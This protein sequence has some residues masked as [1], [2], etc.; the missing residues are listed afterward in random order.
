MAGLY[1]PLGAQIWDR[2]LMWQPIP[3][4]TL[5]QTEDAV[6]AM[7]KKCPK[8]DLLLRQLKKS[9]VFKDLDRKLRD[10][11]AYVTKNTGRSTASIQDLEYVYNTLFIE[12]LYNFTLPNWTKPIYP[13]KLKPWAGLSFAIGTYT[14]ELARLKTGPF[15]HQLRELFSNASAQGAKFHVFSA[16]DL[17]IA[18]LLNAL[19]IFEYHAPP[20]TSTIIFELRSSKN[21]P[22]VNVFYKNSS[23]PQNMIL[24]DCNFDC[25]LSDFVGILEPISVSL[26]QWHDECKIGILTMA[27]IDDLKTVYVFTTIA[28][29]S[30][31]SL[32]VAVLVVH[33]RRRRKNIYF[34]LPDD[35]ADA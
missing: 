27:V 19:G 32:I 33:R 6:L 8:Y 15:F 31:L 22:Y 7:E 12:D 20:Y 28:S 34:R 11:Y 14:K 18:S 13:D 3:I 24:K 1:P 17:T 21:G 9:P 30:L 16:H 5:P 10:L 23:V 25:P 2:N 4:H 26:P 29:V 35:C